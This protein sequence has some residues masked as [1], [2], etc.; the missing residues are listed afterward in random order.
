MINCSVTR[1]QHN[2][3]S[4]H[5]NLTSITVGCSTPTPHQCC[6][7]ECNSFTECK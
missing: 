7:T 4:N 1:C 2:D 6:D 5:C 3:Q